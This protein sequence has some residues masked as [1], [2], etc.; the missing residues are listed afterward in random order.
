MSDLALWVGEVG[1][2]KICQSG[3]KAGL[4]CID[5]MIQSRIKASIESELYG[6]A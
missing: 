5:Y 6:S 3:M 2:D 1:A 4:F